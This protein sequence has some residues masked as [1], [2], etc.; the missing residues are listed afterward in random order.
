MSEL[1]VRYGG[2]YLEKEEKEKQPRWSR[3]RH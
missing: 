2:E 1:V 3:L